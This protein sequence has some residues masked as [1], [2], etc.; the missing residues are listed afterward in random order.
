MR[1]LK[2]LTFWSYV[3][4]TEKQPKDKQSFEQDIYIYIYIRDPHVGISLT[5]AL[6]YPRQTQTLCSAPFLLFSMGNGRDVLRFGSVRPGIRKTFCKKTLGCF[7]PS[8]SNP[9]QPVECYTISVS[10][11]RPLQDPLCDLEAL[12]RPI[13]HPR[14][15][16]ISQP[17]RSKPLKR[18]NRAIVVPLC[19]KP[20]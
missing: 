13:S 14:T 11:P 6:G 7:F 1:V 4:R 5:P 16:G 12:S 10:R 20:L 19:L 2:L 3:I 18:L 8:L 9:P 17:P 15:G